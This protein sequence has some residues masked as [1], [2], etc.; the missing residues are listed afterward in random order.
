MSALGLYGSLALICA[1]APAIGQAV[2]ALSGPETII[3]AIAATRVEPRR[4]VPL[5]DA[6]GEY[7][8]W[9]RVE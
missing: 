7:V 2:V 3:G 5:S 1:A 9:Y 6:C 8:D 4:T